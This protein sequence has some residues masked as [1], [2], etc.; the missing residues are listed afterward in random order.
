MFIVVILI[1]L[2]VILYYLDREFF[3]KIAR[4]IF[5]VDKPLKNRESESVQ[6]KEI[7]SV[8]GEGLLLAEIQRIV[9]CEIAEGLKI[10]TNGQQLSRQDLVQIQKNINELK[11]LLSSCLNQLNQLQRSQIPISP[12][13]ILKNEQQCKNLSH[14]FYAKMVDSD[15][16]YG[17]YVKNLQNEMGGCCF[18]IT[19]LN[20][21][22]AVYEVVDDPAIHREMLAVFDSLIANSSSFDSIPQDAV[23]IRTINKGELVLEEDVW[24]IN[25]KQFVKFI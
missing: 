16:P 21:N 2:S 15:N 7:D 3:K 18:K 22:K 23:G 6:N 24:R 14:T 13:Q 11:D 12:Q 4:W 20:E 9:K 19:I 8:L 10:V 1:S 17:F 25:I 5:R